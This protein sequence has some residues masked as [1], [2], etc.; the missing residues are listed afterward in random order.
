[1][2]DFEGF[3]EVRVRK[4]GEGGRE[5]GVGRERGEEGG[6]ERGREG[7]RSGPPATF[8]GRSLIPPSSSSWQA[9]I[10]LCT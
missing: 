5:R 2:G 4:Q 3:G 6:R 1:L 8:P 9:R 10:K 7:G